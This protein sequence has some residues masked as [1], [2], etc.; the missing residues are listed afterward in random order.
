MQNKYAG[1]IGDYLKLG[2]LRA[3]SPGRKLGVAWW[4]HPDGGPVG[5]GQHTKYLDAGL[6]W[7]P[8]DPPLF[9]HLREI[10]HTG[11]RNVAALQDERL[12]P[13]ARF[14]AEQIPVTCGPSERP[15]QR[16]AWFGRVKAALAGCDLVFADPDNGIEPAGY[17]PTMGNSGKSITW[18]E[19]AA[20]RAPGRALVVY[21]HQTRF[22]GGHINELKHLAKGLRARGCAA[23]D[24]LRAKPYSPR[25]FF[26][27]EA[28]AELRSRAEALS[29]Q[30]GEHLSW[31]P[32]V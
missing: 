18:D 9:D 4:L 8:Y 21:H 20:L 2:I 25:A 11:R 3:L 30:W 7:R 22:K 29:R 17:K 26:L 28:D 32:E 6:D 13:G 5:D 31:H 1:D 23:V 14:A 16:A 15:I 19:I 10:V 24:V 12:L 27:L